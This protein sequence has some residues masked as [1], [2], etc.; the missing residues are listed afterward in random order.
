MSRYIRHVVGLATAT[1][2]VAVLGADAA[3][4]DNNYSEQVVAAGLTSPT[5]IAFLPDRRLLVTEKDGALKLVQGGSATTLTTIPVC[6]GS[7]MGLL[8]IALDPGFAANGFVYLYRT[9]FGTAGCD[10]ATG[11]FNQVVRVTMSGD[12]V[13]AGSLTELLTGIRT[14]GGNHDGGTLRGSVPD[15]KLWVASGTPVT[16]TAACPDNPRT[17]TR[18]TWAR[19][20]GRSCGSS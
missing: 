2:A 1:L 13:V 7:E 4:V 14:D 19:S 9:K 11:R 12:T 6:T 8:G 20:R 10:S 18:R 16:A 17:R 3:P 15:N 5:A